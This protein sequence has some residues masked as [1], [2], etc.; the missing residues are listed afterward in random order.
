MY[1]RLIKNQNVFIFGVLFVEV[2]HVERWF[3]ALIFGIF[4]LCAQCRLIFVSN[5]NNCSF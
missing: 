2:D 5:N 3:D 4:S 1:K